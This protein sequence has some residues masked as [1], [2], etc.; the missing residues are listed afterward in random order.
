M[1]K[2][3]VLFR[4]PDCGSCGIDL[5]FVK[6]GIEV[7]NHHSTTPSPTPPAFQ[8]FCVYFT[9]TTTP[10]PPMPA[11]APPPRYAF[12]PPADQKEKEDEDNEEA[13]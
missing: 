6:C 13:T 3:I 11:Y 2:R 5:F 10:V 4:F 1:R 9:I 8:P 7:R 12:A